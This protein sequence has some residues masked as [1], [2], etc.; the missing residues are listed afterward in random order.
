MQEK[1]NIKV[2]GQ[3]PYILKPGN[4]LLITTDLQLNVQISLLMAIAA[5]AASSG[6]GVAVVRINMKQFKISEI[7][8][9]HTKADVFL[10]G[11][12]KL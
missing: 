7:S 1:S 3:N 8:I 12:A 10:K 2:L 5:E 9:R 4:N 11:T 6:R